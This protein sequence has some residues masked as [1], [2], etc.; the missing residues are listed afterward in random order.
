MGFRQPV[1]SCVASPHEQYLALQSSAQQRHSLRGLDTY[2]TLIRERQKRW[3][4]QQEHKPRFGKKNFPQRAGNAVVAR[5]AALFK[6]SLQQ[7]T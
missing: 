2:A 3:C 5:A 4:S 1:A 7:L 6:G